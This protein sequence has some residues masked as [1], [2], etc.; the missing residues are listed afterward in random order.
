MLTHSKSAH[1]Y[2]ISFAKMATGPSLLLV[3]L[4]WWASQALLAAGWTHWVVTEDGRIQ[5]Q[6]ESPLNIKRTDDLVM[7]MRQAERTEQISQMQKDLLAQKIHI[8]ETED[9]E[10]NLEQTFYKTDPDCRAA[11]RQLTDFDLYISTVLPLENKGIRLEDYINIS[12]EEEQPAK[13]LTPICSSIVD[14]P[15][16]I[17]SLEH[18]EGIQN[19]KNLTGLPEP[20]LRSALPKN[21]DLAKLGH[22]IADGMEKNQSS[23]VLYNLAA[24]YWRIKGNANNMIECTRRALHYSPREHRDV[25]LLNLANILHRA[26]YSE[27]AAVVT[28]ASLDISRDFNV[29]YFHLGN[30]YAVL[31]EYNRSVE[32]F[33]K[34]IELQRDFDAAIKR[35]HAVLCHFK[36]EKALEA[37]HRSLERTLSELKDYQRLH[38]VYLEQ[39]STRDNQQSQRALQFESHL[40][41][42]RQG[43]REGRLEEDQQQCTMKMEYGKQIVVCNFS[44]IP[45]K[46]KDT[47]VLSE[48]KPPLPAQPLP[49]HGSAVLPD[50]PPVGTPTPNSVPPADKA[51]DKLA[52]DQYR[53]PLW[54]SRED[55]EAKVQRLP[56]WNEFPTTY[57]PPENKGFQMHELLNEAVQ[58]TEEE[59]HSLPWY[60]PVCTTVVNLPY[61]QTAYDHVDGVGKREKLP[62]KVLDNNMKAP[63]IL[64]AYRTTENVHT[65]EIGQ[66]ILS[67]IEQKAE[68][69]WTLFNLAG[70][71]WRVAGNPYQA[72][73]CIRRAL[74][75]VPSQ[76]T[77]VP[78]VNMANVLHQIG[79]VD[80]AITLLHEALRFNDT[81]PITHFTLGTA[82]AAKGQMEQAMESLET[83]LD[84]D[85]SY[86]AAFET[87]RIL[88]C[89]KK[90]YNVRPQEKSPAVNRIIPCQH[91]VQHNTPQCKQ[92]CRP[93][94][95]LAPGEA[96]CILPHNGPHVQWPARPQ[97]QKPACQKCNQ[98]RNG[99]PP[100]PAPA[101][102]GVGVITGPAKYAKEENNA[103]VDTKHSDKGDE[104]DKEEDSSGEEQDNGGEEEEG[105]T[106]EVGVGTEEETA[107]TEQDTVEESTQLTSDDLE[108]EEEVIEAVVDAEFVEDGTPV[109]MES[110]ESSIQLDLTP[111]GPKGTIKLLE[112]LL[113]MEE[114]MHCEE[115]KT[116]NVHGFRIL[117]QSE[118]LVDQGDPNSHWITVQVKASDLDQD[119]L[120]MGVV[121]FEGT[122]DLDTLK[123]ELNIAENDADNLL[124][125]ESCD[126]KNVAV[127][128]DSA[129]S[130][131]LPVNGPKIPAANPAPM[132]KTH[133]SPGW[134]TPDDCRG[135]KKINIHTFTST[136]LS[137]TAKDVNIHDHI[138]FKSKL[139][140]PLVEPVCTADVVSMHTLD[141]LDGVAN[142]S[143]INYGP[144]L[145]LKEV[146]Q[147]VGGDMQQ[148]EEVGTRIAKALAKNQTSWI[149][150]S[151]AALYWR[152]EGNGDRA[153]DCLRQALHFSQHRMKDV[154]L[155]GM[156]NIFHRTGLWHDARVVAQMA[157]EIAPHLVVNH[158][159]LANIYAA[160]GDIDKALKYYEMTVI[161][162]GEFA[163]AM[164]RLRT[165]Q[166]NILMKR[167]REAEKDQQ[168]D[169][170]G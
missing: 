89:Y 8:E 4:L 160:M 69:L 117:D 124:V 79:K 167:Q 38:E 116:M 47:P 92:Q 40:Q 70:L 113:G 34:T 15:Y 52:Y 141:H 88:R 157:V 166:C 115:G 158:F 104:E 170:R 55:C 98:P 48:R 39:I 168:K 87:L 133:A 32:C 33:D 86:T 96:L 127:L 2:L 21:E 29:K 13:V 20:G 118:T 9:K 74:H 41:Y 121:N 101:C 10:T 137:V 59:E 131:A 114:G 159:T 53:D 107:A 62:K 35:R 60:K 1:E 72:I 56:G 153:I 44:I 83:A 149:L 57:L 54:P 165:L 122:V 93:P 138:N 36:L 110:D 5:Q 128:Q 28:H 102:M 106:E 103:S 145:G 108:E 151:M 43:I 17:H 42:Q 16:S 80:D 65:E 78:L 45:P 164:E 109:D 123:E 24:F 18:L 144:E 61:T 46:V 75:F 142:R 120:Q 12:R 147:M 37:Q 14:L 49:P 85:P 155:I 136:W 23:W 146:L 84:I 154:A 3:C 76:Y 135:I 150:L 119:L 163:P 94:M 152:V 26:R 25:A 130:P 77:D 132:V 129:P 81:E 50:T 64:A 91:V 68:P 161:I 112:T 6:F 140:G 90:F 139:S 95:V 156:A 11:K 19:R 125:G 31:S 143:S 7:F 99:K 126:D 162:Q 97:C 134:P 66:R 82:K 27:E 73:E 105:K 67:A 71:Y 63:L 169:A 22:W 100:E 58:L 111:E 30:V 51:S 148:A